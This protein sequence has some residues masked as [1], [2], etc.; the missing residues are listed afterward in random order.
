MASP[1]DAQSSSV[2]ISAERARRLDL[3]PLARWADLAPSELQS[4]HGHLELHFEWPREA[5]D[6]RELSEIPELRLWCLRADALH[7]WLPLLLERSGG[8]LTLYVA[9]LLP[10]AFNRNE[11]I[12]FPPKAWSCGSPTACFSWTPGPSPPDSPAARVW[13]RWRRYWALSWIPSSGRPW[14]RHDLHKALDP[15]AG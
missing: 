9:M 14:T 8:G 7:P 6:P 12:R 15:A 13:A 4:W 5:G 1:P 3:A 11:G 10:H 2:L